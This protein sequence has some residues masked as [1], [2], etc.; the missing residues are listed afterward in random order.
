MPSQRDHLKEISIWAEQD[1][2][3]PN[4]HVNRKH[5]IDWLRN[6]NWNRKTE[7]TKNEI[8]KKRK[9]IECKNNVSI[10]GVEAR[11]RTG[12]GG[13]TI[14]AKGHSKI[15]LEFSSS[16]FRPSPSPAPVKVQSDPINYITSKK[17]RHMARG[18]LRVGLLEERKK[19]K[20]KW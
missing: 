5:E 13:R 9:R 17:S 16:S 15:H 20:V 12:I 10:G 14:N 3:K 2:G 18:P 19:K 8:Q 6:W 11:W 1:I 7:K 4:A